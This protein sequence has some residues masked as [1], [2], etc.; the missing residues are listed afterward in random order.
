MPHE[1]RDP[2]GL[3]KSFPCLHRSCRFA[4]WLDC[5]FEITMCNIIARWR[6]LV[7]QELRDQG[8]LQ[9]N[10]DDGK[11]WNLRIATLIDLR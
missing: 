1:P 10:D 8:L 4:I 3:R 2:A 11:K 7:A 6:G 9:D 5:G